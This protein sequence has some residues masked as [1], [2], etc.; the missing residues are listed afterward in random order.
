MTK[1]RR[2]RRARTIEAA[3]VPVTDG[4]HARLALGRLSGAYSRILGQ[5]RHNLTKVE[6]SVSH[7]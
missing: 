1:R 4:K 5:T 6:R 7:V 3:I 2:L